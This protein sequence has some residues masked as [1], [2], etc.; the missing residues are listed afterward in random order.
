MKRLLVLVGCVVVLLALVVWFF[1]TGGRFGRRIQRV[2]LISMDATRA[3]HI[4]CYG[5]RRARTPNIDAVAKEGILFKN[6]VSPVP[7]TLPAHS[8]IMT[9]TIP[10]YHGVHDNIDYR[11]GDSNGTLAEIM[12]EKD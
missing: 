5:Y 4:G 2:V 6:V 12:K 3:D 9:G 1:L 8:T 10:P 7:L 11:L